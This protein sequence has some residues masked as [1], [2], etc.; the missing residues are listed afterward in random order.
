MNKKR[1]NAH[2]LAFFFFRF[3][4]ACCCR[5]FLEVTT[6]MSKASYPQGDFR[7]PMKKLDLAWR[8][9]VQSYLPGE[10]SSTE[11]F[12]WWCRCEKAAAEED[13][14]RFERTR[15]KAIAIWEITWR[16][17]EP[18]IG[19]ACF[20]FWRSEVVEFRRFKALIEFILHKDFRKL[21]TA[22]VES[23]HSCSYSKQR[24]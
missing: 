5:S 3:T 6:K 1:G 23:F 15:G 21:L 22:C 20:L 24:Y 14:S 4:H 16:L 18:G 2:E 12:P 19:I 13:P 9:R 17:T 11:L 7:S 8:R 10:D